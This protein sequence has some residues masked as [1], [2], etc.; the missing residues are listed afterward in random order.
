MGADVGAE[1]GRESVKDVRP[2]R[3]M[4]W[5]TLFDHVRLRDRANEDLQAHIH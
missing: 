5:D 3:L 4:V 1:E 2:I